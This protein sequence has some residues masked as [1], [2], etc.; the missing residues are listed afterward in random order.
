[1]PGIAAGSV[2]GALVALGIKYVRGIRRLPRAFVLRWPP[3]NM[4]AGIL[5]FGLAIGFMMGTILWLSVGLAAVLGAGPA[6][7]A[8]PG[9]AFAFVAGFA[10]GLTI[11]LA[12]IY[13]YVCTTPVAA[14]ASATAVSSYHA[15]R[16]TSVIAGLVIGSVAGILAGFIFGLAVG[17][18]AGLGAGLLAALVAVQVPVV[19]L[20]EIVLSVQEGSRVNF[21]H[22]LED[23]LDRQLLRQ[24][25][26]V[27][28]FRHADL[29]DH[30]AA[31]NS[32]PPT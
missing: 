31:M 7:R 17:I 4:L 3:R 16:R 23:A 2:F 13:G 14:S 8:G 29:Q 10:F 9:L 19:K 18:A 32:Q 28:Q 30:L 1:V 20:T 21:R 11:G 5:L 25:G 6:F 24:A 26:T 15:D 22:L 12:V 27:Y